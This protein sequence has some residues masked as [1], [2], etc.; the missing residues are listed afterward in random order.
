M[1]VIKGFGV[2]TTTLY[3]ISIKQNKSWNALINRGATTSCK[4][5]DMFRRE[6]DLSCFKSLLVTGLLV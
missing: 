1:R 6:N 2:A 4:N 5:V 3:I